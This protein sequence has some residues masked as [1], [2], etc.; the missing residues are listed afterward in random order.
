MSPKKLW[1]WQ[2]FVNGRPEFW[3]FDNAYPCQPGPGDPITLGE[4]AGYALV[5]DSVCGRAYCE[6]DV[7]ADIVATNDE[8]ERALRATIAKLQA[9]KDYVHK[10]LDDAGIPTHPEG[11]HSAAG[12]RI[13]DRLDMVFGRVSRA[14]NERDAAC[15][16]SNEFLENNRHLRAN[17]AADVKKRIAVEDALDL[18]RRA[19][20]GCALV[21]EACSARNSTTV[22]RVVAKAREILGGRDGA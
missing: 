4:P 20:E 16:A 17:W 21:M 22:K 2:N 3:A 11:E 7:I 6:D 14:I 19:L 12:C 1:L 18:T 8:S 10:R 13:G 9:F 15:D 5:M